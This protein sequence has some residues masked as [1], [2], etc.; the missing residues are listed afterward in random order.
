MKRLLFSS[1]FVLTLVQTVSAVDTLAKDDLLRTALRDNPQV[2]A[3][4]A[5]WKAAKQRIPQARAWEDLMVGVDAV[6]MGPLRLNKVDDAEF[7]VSQAIPISGK[8][9]SRARASLAEALAAFQEYRRTQLDVLTRAQS[10]YYRLSGAYGQ[11]EIN[12]RNQELLKQFAEI[13]RRKYEV[14]T[15]T[16]SDVLL[17]ETE[18]A[19]LSETKAV[20]E[21]EIS[22]QQS[23]INILINCP[24]TKPVPKPGPLTFQTSSLQSQKVETLAARCRP[25]VLMAW[26]K[27]EAERARLQLAHR[28]WI[29]DPT[30]KVTT[31][32]FNSDQDFREV[33]AGISFNVPWINAKK[34]SAGVAEAEDNLANAKHEYETSQV[35]AT[36]LVR[37]QLKKIETFAT[38]YRLFH[39]Q[40]APTAK[41]TVESTRAGYETDKSGFLDLLTARRTLQDIESSGLTQLIEHEVAVAE[42]EATVGVSPYLCEPKDAS[43]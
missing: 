13:S 32:P 37:D 5:R 7:M 35:A 36:A 28:Q 43:K 27:I 18:L 23:Q 12:Q 1:L 19:R 31:R 41:M 11:L 33:T 4:C 3:A 10:A 42:L 30:F 24:A 21:R 40:I 15:A 2:K 22:D 29:P 25:E 6:W 17:A 20:I 16:Q 26:R 38:N 39:D 8:N 34:Y 14:G 9:L